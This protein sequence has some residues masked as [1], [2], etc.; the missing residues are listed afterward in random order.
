MNKLRGFTLVELII[1]IAIL[2][3]LAAFAIPKFINVDKDARES[4]VKGLSGAMRSA[5]N[6]VYSA[7]VVQKQAKKESATVHLDRSDI[8]VYFGYPSASTGSGP[9]TIGTIESA[10]ST[11]GIIET[12]GDFEKV[13]TENNV[14]YKH[15]GA[16]TPASC[17]VTYSYVPS[18]SAEPTITVDV[19]DCS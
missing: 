7:A 6:V 19:S 2:G 18:A 3:I 9:Y 5:V 10:M 8:L 16:A 11:S 14:V 4:V 12:N 15:K 1:V 17:S 13:I